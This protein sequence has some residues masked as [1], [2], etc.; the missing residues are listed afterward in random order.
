MSVSSWISTAGYAADTPEGQS[1]RL[2]EPMPEAVSETKKRRTLPII[3]TP[4][5]D[6]VQPGPVIDGHLAFQVNDHEML[7]SNEELIEPLQPFPGACLP[8]IADRKE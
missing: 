2:G 3:S 4:G 6:S 7:F 8:R 1:Q 5:F